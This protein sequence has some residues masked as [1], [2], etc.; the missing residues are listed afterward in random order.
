V[1]DLVDGIARDCLDGDPDTPGDQPLEDGDVACATVNQTDTPSPWPFIPKFGVQN[2]FPQ[3]SFFEG[4][5]NISRL[6]PGAGCFNGILAETR[7]S[8]PFD[9]RLKDFALGSFS[10][11]GAKISINPT[12]AANEI[13]TN[14]ALTIT[15]EKKDGS[16]GFAFG[17][18]SGVVVAAN[19]GGVGG[20]VNGINT[21]TTDTTGTCTVTITSASPGI[22]TVSANASVPLVGN[23]S[24][25]V[26]TS[27]SDGNS[28]P[29]TKTWVD[30]NIQITPLKAANQIGHDHTFTGHVNVN[31]GTGGYVNAP[32]GTTISF[33]VDSGPGSR[34]RNTCTTAGGTGSCSVTLASQATG[35]AEVKATSDVTVMGVPLHRETDSTAGNS[36]TAK[37][38]WVSPQLT[39]DPNEAANE[40]GHD[41]ILTATLKF[42]EGDNNLVSAPDG[43]TINFSIDL[44]TGAQSESGP[45]CKTVSGICSIT[46]RSNATGLITVTA[47]WAG[48]IGTDVGTTRPRPTDSVKL[49]GCRVFFNTGIDDDCEPGNDQPEGACR[50][51]GRARVSALS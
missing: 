49:G 35:V 20:F 39:L 16:N 38:R 37:K 21:C 12:N 19:I 18:A 13:G 31:S 9:S 7:S 30:A 24:V 4:G 15:V 47:S 1:L 26:S 50:S 40:I 22:T 11:C 10:L 3:G 34:R 28:G 29:A 6:I 36:G 42:N 45:S 33:G 27:G 5:I 2:T 51:I 8:T 48:N 44:G 43:E 46:I 25:A 23:G 14:H 17:P 32:D 41:H